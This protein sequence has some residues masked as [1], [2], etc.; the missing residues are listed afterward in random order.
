MSVSQ[1]FT[2]GTTTISPFYL[3]SGGSSAYCEN[4]MVATLDCSGNDIDDANNITA[5]GNIVSTG[6]SVL[7]NV[8]VTAQSGDIQ[9]AA[10][11]VIASTG[12][13]LAGSALAVD[14]SSLYAGIRALSV[15]GSD[16][17]T[18]PVS[19]NNAVLIATYNAPSAVGWPPLSAAQTAPGVFTV[20]G[21][22][23]QSFFYLIVR[24]IV[25]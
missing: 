25:T 6:G 14:D 10:G 7:A 5:N 19:D 9:T 24:K 11:N 3:P 21:Q 22:A 2:P 1:I 8:G 18:V 20:T 17:I 4:P 23:S 12:Y 16:T 13:V 15:G